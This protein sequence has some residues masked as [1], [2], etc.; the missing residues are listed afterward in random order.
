MTK[1]EKREKLNKLIKQ[2]APDW[3]TEDEYR[4][5]LK[6]YSSLKQSFDTE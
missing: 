6:N 1:K 5:Y 2:S 4:K 3:L